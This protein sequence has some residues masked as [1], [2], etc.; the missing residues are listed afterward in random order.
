[1]DVD[2]ELKKREVAFWPSSLL[3]FY[4]TY[5]NLHEPVCTI[6]PFLC[7]VKC[8]NLSFFSKFYSGSMRVSDVPVVLCAFTI[9]LS[10]QS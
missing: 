8:P 7:H 2:I 6:S 1:M 3:Q 9:S 10:I 4:L 5:N